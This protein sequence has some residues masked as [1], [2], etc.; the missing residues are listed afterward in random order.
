MHQTL[1]HALG[2]HIA[3]FSCTPIFTRWICKYGIAM[4]TEWREDTR[5]KGV[6]VHAL[7]CNRLV[8]RKG[9]LQR[10]AEKVPNGKTDSR[11]HPN[12]RR[13]PEESPQRAVCC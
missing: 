6:C 2:M 8:S 9:S 13:N 10:S 5:S 11:L 3:V 4:K 7:G 12:R 1:T